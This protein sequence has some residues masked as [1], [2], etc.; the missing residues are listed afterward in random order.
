MANDIIK[1]SS[2]SSPLNIRDVM[3]KNSSPGGARALGP[4]YAQKV[5]RSKLGKTL[6]L[7]KDA[8]P[9]RYK[10]QVRGGA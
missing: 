7:E 9:F 2:I 3:K 5:P 4:T 1:S 10:S 6:M 8:M